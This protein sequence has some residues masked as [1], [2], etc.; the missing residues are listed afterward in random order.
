MLKIGPRLNTF[1]TGT[2]DGLICQKVGG[3]LERCTRL[4]WVEGTGAVQVG[5][6]GSDTTRETV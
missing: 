6:N 5:S 3:Y 2:N 4:A 1:I